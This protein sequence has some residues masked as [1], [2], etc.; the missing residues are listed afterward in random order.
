MLVEKSEFL[1]RD[2][3]K[4][5]TD[6][7]TRRQ[8][9]CKYKI[10]YREII[11]ITIIIYDTSRLCGSPCDCSSQDA[12]AALLGRH[13]RMAWLHTHTQLYCGMPFL[14]DTYPTTYI[15]KWEK[16]LNKHMSEKNNKTNYIWNSSRIIGILGKDGF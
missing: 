12:N 13:G 3:K 8:I 10:K 5:S 6:V 14:T 7:F 4:K 15:Y 1:I 2:N 11:R 9:K 16:H